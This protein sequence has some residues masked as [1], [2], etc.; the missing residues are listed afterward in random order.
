M[1]KMKIS[2]KPMEDSIVDDTL[3]EDNEEELVEH[4]QGETLPHGPMFRWRR[5][6]RDEQH[7]LGNID[8]PHALGA[9]QDR[10]ENQLWIQAAVW[11]KK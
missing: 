6:P 8:L 11:I 3:H 7:R 4:E 2:F 5:V 9:V 10:L 1:K